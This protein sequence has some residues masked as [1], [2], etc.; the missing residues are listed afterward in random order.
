[1]LRLEPAIIRHYDS[2]VGRASVGGDVN[3]LTGLWFDG[4]KQHFADNPF[5]QRIPRWRR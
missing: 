4:A 3:E 2:M 5:R 1:M